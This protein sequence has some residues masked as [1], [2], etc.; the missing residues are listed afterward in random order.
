MPPPGK[1]ALGCLAAAIWGLAA[2]IFASTSE[3]DAAPAQRVSVAC[4][5]LIQEY[6]GRAAVASDGRYGPRASA[7]KAARD[8]S[9]ERYIGA[10]CPF[11]TLLAADH[12]VAE[13]ALGLPP[14]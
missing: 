6:I 9:G 1:V 2:W 10:G 5:P 13:R 8:T 3:G 12:L 4:A 7:L 14:L 11:G